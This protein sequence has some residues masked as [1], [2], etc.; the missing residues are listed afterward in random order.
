MFS[1]SC[2]DCFCDIRVTAHHMLHLLVFP[3]L[4]NVEII[5]KNVK[6]VTVMIKIKKR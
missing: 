5:I 6:N 3:D 2:F 1:V 4:K